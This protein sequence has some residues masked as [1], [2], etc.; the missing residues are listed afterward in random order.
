MH[1]D[2]HAS[3][4]MLRLAG[5]TSKKDLLAGYSHLASEGW[6]ELGIYSWKKFRGDKPW[7]QR[8]LEE[9]NPKS[10]KM[11]ERFGPSPT[12]EEQKAASVTTELQPHQQRV[13]DR[14]QDD[15]QR[16]LIVAHG[17]GSGKT[18]TSIAVADALGL[19]ADVVVPA[20]LRANYMKEV[21]KHTDRQ[22]G[23]AHV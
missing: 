4:T 5:K 2:R 3:L 11:L 20:S 13:V 16:G 22:I 23:R 18:L 6:P 14:M 15:D 7:G 8:L 1:K 10:F 17:L 12:Y 9:Q 21:Q 19:P